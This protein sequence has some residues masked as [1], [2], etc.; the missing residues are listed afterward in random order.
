MEWPLRVNFDRG[1]RFC[2]PAHFGFAPEE[3]LK[4]LNPPDDKR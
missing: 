1:G 4:T 3:D 2:L